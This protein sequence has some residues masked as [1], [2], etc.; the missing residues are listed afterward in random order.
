MFKTKVEINILFYVMEQNIAIQLFW[1][2]VFV[3]KTWLPENESWNAIFWSM[4]LYHLL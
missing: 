1:G 4:F 3:T 2:Y